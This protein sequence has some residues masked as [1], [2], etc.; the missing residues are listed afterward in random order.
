MQMS[1]NVVKIKNEDKYV[2]V[3]EISYNPRDNQDEDF[4]SREYYFRICLIKTWFF[5]AD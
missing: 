1:A 4:R 5:M 3:G 2:L